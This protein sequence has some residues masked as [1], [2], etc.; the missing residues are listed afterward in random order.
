MG[1]CILHILWGQSPI[2]GGEKLKDY[3]SEVLPC[4]VIGS[5]LL[6]KIEQSES[7]FSFKHHYITGAMDSEIL[8]FIF[9]AIREKRSI[10]LETINRYK[11]RITEKY[12]IPVKV[13]ISVQSGRQ[14]L[15]AYTP[16]FKRITPFRTDNI[17]SIK[18]DDKSP[19]FDELQHTFTNML[20][21]I[22]GVST[23]GNTGARIEHVE[24]TVC[25]ADEEKHI[26]NRLEREKRCG[27]VEH[28][29]NNTSRFSAD[30]FDAS[31][32]IPWIRTFYHAACMSPHI[33][34]I[35]PSQ[36]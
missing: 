26:R 17:I 7:H 4:G 33:V 6:D 24:F 23:Q 10:T 36:V 35:W 18:L 27:T 21:H 3:F 15:M 1:D 32:V 29:D 2:P 28:L 14:Y 31:E 34:V 8:Y 11:D 22:W 30:V 25:Y 5:Y 20:P 13:M 9:L 16:R 12:V 19:R